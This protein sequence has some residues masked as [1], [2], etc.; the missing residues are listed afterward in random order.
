MAAGAAAA[1]AASLLG[2]SDWRLS[3]LSHFRLHLAAGSLVGL[4]AS[5]ASR[6]RG[7]AA[8]LAA[9]LAANLADT[10]RREA[11]R[12]AAASP[13]GGR[14]GSAAVILVSYNARRHNPRKRRA[15]DW[16]A[17]S[18]ADLAVVVEVTPDW[19]EALLDGLGPLYPYR[20]FGPDNHGA[21]VA[22]LSR[23]PLRRL[24]AL[25]IDDQGLVAVRVGHPD[26]PFTLFAVHPAHAIRRRS[27]RPQRAFLGRLA[28]LVR[29]VGG[30]VA[31][32]GDL[33]TTPWS[34]EF[35]RLL[36]R[37]GLDGP[38]LRAGTFPAKLGR[39]GLP[40]DHVLAGRGLHVATVA[41]GPDL[42]SDHRPVI[43]RL[44]GA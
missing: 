35:R 4:A 6:R 8:L 7:P 16:I 9:A 17:R 14:W 39:F 1:T 21:G 43:T 32:A 3:L 33:N 38:L 40:I 25:D 30:P 15:L 44:A 12:P 31:V 28:A 36:A 10:L 37:S 2:R 27:L 24:A 42:G 18:G 19:R 22:V 5:A 20:A 34:R 23:H 26:L 41:P 29:R 13:S 11:A